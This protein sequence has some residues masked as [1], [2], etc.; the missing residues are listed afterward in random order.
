[1]EQLQDS[2]FNLNGCHITGSKG[3]R[4]FTLV[5]LLVVIAIIGILIALLLPAIQAAREAARRT[6]CS[7]NERQIG[8]A[9]LSYLDA[10]KTFPPGQQQGCYKCVPWAWSALILPFMEE[11]ALYARFVL[12]NQPDHIPNALADL[13]GPTQTVL[14]TFLC[15]STSRLNF[16]RGDNS[17]IN[18][19]NHNGR[20]DPGEG[21]GVTD[22][23]GVRGPD[24]TSINPTTTQ[25]Y[26]VDRGILLALPNTSTTPG[27]LV[28]AVI[29]PRQITDG[30]SK[31]MVV[32]EVS[33]R[34]YDTS[35]SQLRGTWANG[36]NV[37]AVTGGT[38]NINADP[39]LTWGDVGGTYE[40]NL[41][42][43]DHPGGTNALFC[44]DSVHFLSDAT[45]K[46]I[47]TALA[48]RDGGEAIPAGIIGN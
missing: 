34:G 42:L 14:A 25:S 39:S 31:T 5:E 7:N 16:S 21:L 2:K 32:V 13:S 37:L 30:M 11:S 47:V 22:Y 3:D 41:I 40:G 36:Y 9:L 19:F 35:R 43:C 27:V 28:A 15:P 26:N 46:T 1:M 45:D 24:A 20:W 12:P 44:D 33:G 4:G 23:A 10:K 18:D 8:L 38:S 48:S 29:A 6:Q 17:R